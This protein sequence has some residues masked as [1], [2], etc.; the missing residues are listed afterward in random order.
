MDLKGKRLVDA[1]TFQSVPLALGRA[2]VDAPAISTSANQYDRLLTE[3]PDITVPNFA[4]PTTKHGV[5]HFITTKGPPV[6]AHAR[7]LPPGKLETARAEF[8][9][10][11]E[12]GIIRRSSSSWAS[13][14]TWCLKS[15]EVGDH[16]ATIDASMMLP[17]LIATRY[18]IFRIL[19]PTWQGSTFSRRLTLCAATTRYQSLQQTYRK[20]PSSPHLGFSSS[21]ECHLA[22]RT[23]PRLSSD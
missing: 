8:N 17:F 19:Q 22:S 18:P 3:F 13:P 15:L 21:S 1:E 14:Y 4:Q 10:M 12:M 5:E 11:Q 7:R 6:H 9:R 20:L 2:Q 23:R 16:V